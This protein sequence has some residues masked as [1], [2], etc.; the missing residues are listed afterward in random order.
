MISFFHKPKFPPVYQRYREAAKAKLPAKMPLDQVRFVVLDTETSGLKVGTDRI[1]SL[2]LFE[3]IT[4]RI[5]VAGSRKWIVCQ[6][7]ACLNQATAVHGILPSEIR[8]GTPEQKILEELLPLLSGAVI[9][10]HHVRF[11][12]AMINDMMLR[13]MKAG[14]CNCVVDTARLAMRE[15]IPFHQTGYANQRPPSMEEVC[16]QLDLPPIARHTAEGDAF[17]T[18]EIFLS[19]CGRIRRRLTR[20]LQVRDLPIIR[21]RK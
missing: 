6:P 5:Y 18:A 15:L 7:T 12:A 19:L 20:P 16:A 10:G 2:A 9:V 4:E 8:Q 13:Q 11:D 17:V 14:F 3:V 1:L 21:Y